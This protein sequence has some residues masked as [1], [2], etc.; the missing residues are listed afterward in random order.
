VDQFPPDRQQQI[1]VMLADSLK[2]SISQTLLKKV[3]GGRIAAIESLFIT[4]AI[5]NLIRE[6][7]NYQIVS[8][9]Q[10]GRAYGQKL[11]NDALMELIQAGQID[12]MEAYMKCPDKETFMATLKRNNYNWDPRG[13]DRP[14]PL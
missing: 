7:K 5:A 14:M 4:P 13:D 9:M 6:A 12:P 3:G 1:R 11:M 8:A 2:A 10:T